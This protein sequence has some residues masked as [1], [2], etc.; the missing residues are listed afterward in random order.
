MYITLM[1]AEEAA[2][3]EDVDDEEEKAANFLQNMYISSSTSN[4]GKHVTVSM[5]G[6][7]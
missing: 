5:I 6:I 2:E 7:H 3:E 4:L 1:A